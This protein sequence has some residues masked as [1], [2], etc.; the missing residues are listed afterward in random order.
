MSVTSLTQAEAQARLA[1]AEELMSHAHQLVQSMQ[2]RTMQMT[3]SSWQGTQASKFAQ[4]MQGH[5]DDFTAILNS[6][7]HVVETGKQNINTQVNVEAE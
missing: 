2:D 5:T 1:Q 7:R 4:A 3:A 6:L